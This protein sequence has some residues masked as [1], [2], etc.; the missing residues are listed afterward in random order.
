[1]KKNLG[2]H[3]S[4][5]NTFEEEINPTDSVIN[6]VDVMLVFSCGLLLALVMFWNVDLKAQDMVSIDQGADVS[7][8]DEVQDNIEQSETGGSGY[9]KMGTVYKDPVTGQLYMLKE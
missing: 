1:M 2:I 4:A 8:I 6:I 3:R 5:R 7:Q 9:E